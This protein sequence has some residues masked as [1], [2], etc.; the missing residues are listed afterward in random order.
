MLIFLC[1]HPTCC[2]RVAKRPKDHGI[3]CA[4]N[5][6][7]SNSLYKELDAGTAPEISTHT[8]HRPDMEDACDF[9]VLASNYILIF[10]DSRN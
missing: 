8:L 5:C 3:D 1:G 6:V 7:F 4:T 10:S 2:T 9:L